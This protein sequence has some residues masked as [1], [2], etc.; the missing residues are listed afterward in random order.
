M[1]GFA[2]YGA[3][4]MMGVRHSLS[5]MLKSDIP[6]LFIMRCVCHS[7]HL[8]TS[9]ACKKLPRWVEDMACDIYNY[10]LSPKQTAAFKDFQEFANVTPHK[11]LHPC[12]TR[13]LSLHIVVKRL[14]EQLPALKLFFTQAALEYRLLSAESILQK[15]Q[16]PFSKLYLEF[17]DHVLPMFSDL[18]KEM[19]S[20]NPKIYTLHN[21]VSAVLH[22]ILD[23]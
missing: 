19:Q 18:N 9:Y 3:S 11:L 20:E 23:C 14:L 5:S 7:L 8:C 22:T 16:D 2:A 21:R 15:L 6:N 12:Q 4:M 10:F 1:I 17:L 13:W